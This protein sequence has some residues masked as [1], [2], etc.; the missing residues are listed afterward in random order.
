[1]REHRL[2]FIGPSIRPLKRWLLSFAILGICSIALADELS[3][4]FPVWLT[5]AGWALIVLYWFGGSLFVLLRFK[6]G[7]WQSWGPV[8]LY[9]R[10]LR[11]SIGDEVGERNKG[12]TQ[13]PD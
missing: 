11:N 13:N 1:M 8:G 9:P 10:R 2:R 6:N 4:G 3:A 5:W 7:N 12:R